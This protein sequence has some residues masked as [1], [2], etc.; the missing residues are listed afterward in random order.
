[1]SFPKIMGVVNVTPDSFSDGGKYNTTVD[2][3][4]HA[5]RLID[6]GADMLDIGGESTRPGS[7]SVSVQ[8]ELDRV[9]PVIEG[10]R[11]RNQQIEI[12]IDTM[13]SEVARQVLQVGATMVN[14]VSA[15][16]FDKKMLQVVR[17]YSV[18]YCIM[19]MQGT[20]KSMQNN[21]EY[22]DVVQEVKSFLQERV[23]YVSGE[24]VEKI[25]IDVG[26][27]FGKSI[28]HNMKLLKN[29]DAFNDMNVPML[30]GI[31]RKRFIGELTGIKDPIERDPFTMLIHCLL[32]NKNCS[33]VRVHNVALLR[34]SFE[35]VKAFM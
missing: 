31:S 23:K 19:H 15:G 17:E 29:L 33:I 18:P 16:L 27:G 22:S 13:K 28:D 9:I 25:F 4:N 20:P 2:A 35:V 21:P 3:V 1:M 11:N 14:D 7:E 6:E 26:I 24:G 32:L 12:S 5:L 30:L 34:K 8:S 10:I